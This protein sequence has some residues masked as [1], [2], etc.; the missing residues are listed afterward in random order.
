MRPDLRAT[1]AADP[2]LAAFRN[3]PRFQSSI[4]AQA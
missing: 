1:F 2:D 3:N 4:G